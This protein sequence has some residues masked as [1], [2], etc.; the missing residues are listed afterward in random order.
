MKPLFALALSAL[1]VIPAP[2]FEDYSGPYGL[3][4]SVD[5]NSVTFANGA[6]IFV[7]GSHADGTIAYAL[8]A[9]ARGSNAILIP[10]EIL[11]PKKPETL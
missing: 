9:L 2:P 4:I 5:A 10:S 6:T 1:A 7:C 3:G 11:N 8:D